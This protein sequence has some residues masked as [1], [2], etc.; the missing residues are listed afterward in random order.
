M[1]TPILNKI[2]ELI[3]K[4]KVSFHTP[5]HKG[6]NTLIEWAK[7]VPFGD[8]TELPGLDNLHAPEG[9][10]KES[11]EL[12]AETFG[13]KKTIYSV[14]GTTT[15][16]YIA[17]ATLTQPGDK[18]LIQREAHKSVYNGAILN[19]LRTEYI[20]TNYNRKYHLYTGVDPAEIDKK[21]K[22][23]PDIKVVV[24]TYPNYYGICSDIEKI[25]A[26]VH[27]HDKLLLVDEAHGS[28]F[29]FSDKLP[30]SSLKAGA[31]LVVQSTHKTLPS[32]TQTSMLHVGSDRVDIEKLEEMS[33]LYQ[34]TSPSYLFMASLELARAYME[35]K[36]KEKLNRNIDY[37]YKLTEALK[38]IDKVIVFTG[39]KE[40][41]TIYHKDITKVLLG[42][43][44]VTGTQLSQ[45][46]M[47]HFGIYMEMADFNYALALTSVMNEAE[48]F[49]RL[50]RAVKEIASQVSTKG[51]EKQEAPYIPKPKIKLPIY[52]AYYS[53]KEIIYLKD[54]IGR[55][56]ATFITPYPP[57]VPL[58]CPGELITEELVAY[59]QTA[60]DKSIEIV[61]LIGYNRE[62]IKVVKRRRE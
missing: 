26:I 24:I 21:L 41:R 12:A 60:L 20:Y 10:I 46:L 2:L 19:K 4:E 23:E 22:E 28:H 32:F 47:E 57:G 27:K 7:L 61:G 31:D 5:G 52:E 30:I 3:D 54:S 1:K 17:L 55:I 6:K 53:P 42:I 50:L 58:I 13:A 35:K 48:D 37:I 43:E 11:Q 36:G 39:D 16:I 56:A 44:G 25:A 18:I 15:G 9:I 49:E 14:G 33:S 51:K 38:A 40:D 59:I 34:T 62:K 8:T 45:I 29:V